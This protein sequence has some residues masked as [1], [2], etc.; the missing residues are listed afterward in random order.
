MDC[1]LDA[2][3]DELI[4]ALFVR[5]P[6]ASH[7][8]VRAACRRLD[9][10]LSSRAF[11]AERRASGCAERGVLVAGGWR[12]GESARRLGYGSAADCW[13][14]AADGARWRRAAP[15]RAPRSH[16]C[17]AVYRGELWVLGG[18]GEPAAEPPDRAARELDG[19]FGRVLATVERF[20]ARANAWRAER[21][22]PR[23]REAAA[24]GVVGGRLVVAGGWDDGAGFLDSVDACAPRRPR[25]APRA[26]ARGMK[27][28]DPLHTPSHSQVRSAHRLLAR[29]P[30]AAARD[31]VRERVRARRA[32]LRGRRPRVRQVPGL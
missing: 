8:A 15:L 16:A 22:L 3:S 14:L 5:A 23:P 30:A 18:W 2:L 6:L 13:L 12:G 4:I 26:R 21:A 31:R 32:P 28:R 1:K 9:G 25:R 24:A 20:D 27:N 29:P 10:L 11:R 19:G 17:S 7:R